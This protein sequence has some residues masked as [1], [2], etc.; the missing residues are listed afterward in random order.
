[1]YQ[2]LDI[3]IKNTT[4]EQFEERFYKMRSVLLPKL[5]GL[6]FISSLRYD[7][8]A[9]NEFYFVFDP[10]DVPFYDEKV[11]VTFV[12]KDGNLY[13]HND[14][15]LHYSDD[16]Y[17]KYHSLFP[18]LKEVAETFDSMEYYE[19]WSRLA[20]KDTNTFPYFNICMDKEIE[21]MYKYNNKFQLLSVASKTSEK[22]LDPDDFEKD[23]DEYDK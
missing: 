16:L 13:L 9:S 17:N 23:F 15:G 6:G 18:I 8:L 3:M 5:E 10:D 22:D 19:Y 1:M 21:G 2:N 7:S 12:E 20:F 14:Y 4:A 11:P